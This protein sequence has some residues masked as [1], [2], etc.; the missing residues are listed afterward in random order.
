MVPKVSPFL[1]L[2]RQWISGVIFFE[3]TLYQKSADGT[4]FPEL[5]RK[6]NILVGIKVDEG[7]KV[8]LQCQLRFPLFRVRSLVLSCFGQALPGCDNETATQGLTN[9]DQRCQKYYKAGARFAKWRAVLRIADGCPSDLSI[10]VRRFS[11]ST[12]RVSCH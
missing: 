10:A 5:L 2:A 8:L 7:T 9:L 12:L 4:P 3:E 6:K 11:R 1:P